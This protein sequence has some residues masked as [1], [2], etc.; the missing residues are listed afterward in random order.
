MGISFKKLIVRINCRLNRDYHDI[1]LLPKI[2]YTEYA[3]CNVS[4]T[5]DIMIRKKAV[6]LTNITSKY[7]RNVPE[8]EIRK[9]NY[10]VRLIKEFNM[11]AV[12]YYILKHDD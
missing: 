2:S 11:D 7:K 12:N 4:K 9:P 1:L 8:Y 10:N 5:L 3:I 6:Y